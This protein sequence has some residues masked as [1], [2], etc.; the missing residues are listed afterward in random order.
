MNAFTIPPILRAG[1]ICA[2]SLLLAGG[3][4]AL[5]T[6]ATPVPSFYS[7]D[8]AR[9][10]PLGMASPSPTAPTLIVS[11]PHGAAGFDSSRIIYVRMEHK[12][13]YF[14]HN[15]WTDTPA[16]MV[17]PLIVHSLE[18]SGAFRAVVL[19]PSAAAG[20]LRLD[21]EIIRLQQDFGSVPSGARFTLRATLVVNATRRVLA[22]RE[23]DE[24]VAAPSD[25]PYGGVIAA[26]RAVQAALE[27]M[28]S[29]CAETAGTWQADVQAAKVREVTGS[30]RPSG[31]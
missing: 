4:S 2:A 24:T 15:E 21:T 6:S 9:V 8:N 5:R 18:A 1:L 28:G 12:L 27:K 20:D 16:R 13:E 23:F 14:S 19:S 25:D 3:C 11:P 17:S 22:W 29:F 31:D 7:L 30:A 10:A 26:N